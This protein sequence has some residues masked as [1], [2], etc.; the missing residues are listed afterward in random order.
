[1][2]ARGA[3][4]SG[5]RPKFDFS[6]LDAQPQSAS[7]MT[8]QGQAGMDSARALLGDQN[9]QGEARTAALSDYRAAKEMR[10]AGMFAEAFGEAS[11]KQAMGALSGNDICRAP[12][13]ALQISSRQE[14]R[15]DRTMGKAI[16][17]FGSDSASDMA[18]TFGKD[19]TSGKAISA[20]QRASQTERL[21]AKMQMRDDALKAAGGKRFNEITGTGEE[22]DA[23]RQAALMAKK[24]DRRIN[25]QLGR[26]AGKFGAD[27]AAELASRV[28]VD[29]EKRKRHQQDQ[30]QEGT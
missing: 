27:T 9:I 8:T 12:A 30:L 26:A 11:K 13:G 18:G 2:G 10:K 20:D 23:Q 21:R 3:V 1:M 28:G 29:R 19:Y 7:D 6:G 14:S 25:R 22:A 4:R 5:Y 15:M 16:R 24:M 17:R